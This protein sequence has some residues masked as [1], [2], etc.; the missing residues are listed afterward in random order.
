MILLPV[1]EVPEKYP[2]SAPHDSRVQTDHT[3]FL[4]PTRESWLTDFVY[5]MRGSEVPEVFSLWTALLL[6]S[7]ALRRNSWY[8]QEG[9]VLYTNL[10]VLLVGP[11]GVVKKTTAT[12]EALR[13]ANMYN[14]LWAN[15]PYRALKKIEAVAD[16][17]TSEAL[18]KRLSRNAGARTVRDQN[19]GALSDAD[20]KP[21]KYYPDSACMVIADEI[22]STLRSRYQRGNLDFL[23]AVYSNKAMHSHVTKNS[24]VHIM[25]NLHT[26]FIGN[27]TIDTLS[28]VPPE[29]YNDGF[30]SRMIV[31]YEFTSDKIYDGMFFPVGAPSYEEITEGL[32]HACLLHQGPLYPDGNAIAWYKNWYYN[33][34]MEMQENPDIASMISRQ[35]LF[36]RKLATLLAAAEYTSENVVT[37]EH[38]LDADRLLRYTYSQNPLTTASFSEVGNSNGHPSENYLTIYERASQFLYRNKEKEFELSKL[39]PRLRVKGKFPKLDLVRR[40]VSALADLQNVEL[41]KGN[42]YVRWKVGVP[43]RPQIRK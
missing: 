27:T 11:A 16:D 43:G 14:A 39:P 1:D 32:M 25:R 40:V 36:I 24:G 17:Y 10:Y 9:S 7:S 6:L 37:L 35:Q 28:S 4:L 42:K 3:S 33:K 20:G 26:N 31:A 19:G 41:L 5:L 22:S 15:S 38:F 29:L 21:L 8:Q 23:K 18:I 30:M 2:F 34:R 13:I 12:E